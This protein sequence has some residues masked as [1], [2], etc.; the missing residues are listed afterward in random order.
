MSLADKFNIPQI[1]AAYS[2]LGSRCISGD[3]NALKFLYAN[4]CK[5]HPALIATVTQLQYC[6]TSAELENADPNIFSSEFLYYLGMTDIGEQTRLIQKD[7]GTAEFCFEQIKNEVPKAKARLAY[8]D[9]LLSKEP[10]KSDNNAQKVDLL[11]QWAGKNDMFSKVALSKIIFEHYLLERQ[12]DDLERPTT[13]LRL[14][15]FPCHRGHPVAVK[16]Y[17]EVIDYMV[18][19]GVAVSPEWRLDNSIINAEVLYDF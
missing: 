7:L 13:L 4:L 3:V 6:M 5:E 15:E 2:C 19:L 9:L 10:H 11:R 16:F 8:I 12:D 18:A 1:S 14:L 17:N